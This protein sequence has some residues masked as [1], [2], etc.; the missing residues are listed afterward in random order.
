MVP[1]SW[2]WVSEKT[3][4]LGFSVNRARSFPGSRYKH[5]TKN[6]V[7]DLVLGFSWFHNEAVE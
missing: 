2:I 1:V 5:L 7:F 4:L 3:T 6:S